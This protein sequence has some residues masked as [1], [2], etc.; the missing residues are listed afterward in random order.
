M[1]FVGHHLAIPGWQRRSERKYPCPGELYL[2]GDRVRAE[3]DPCLHSS[4]TALIATRLKLALKIMRTLVGSVI[5]IHVLAIVLAAFSFDL[6]GRILLGLH[7]A[8]IAILVCATP[9]IIIWG[10]HRSYDWSRRT[11]WQLCQEYGNTEVR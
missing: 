3:T 5:L 10:L 1:Q 6:L 11:R 4:R 8:F 9:F 2:R 7:L